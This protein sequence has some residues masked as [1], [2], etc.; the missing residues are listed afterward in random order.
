MRLLVSNVV[1]LSETS[2]DSN[3]KQCCREYCDNIL[4]LQRA[5][6]TKS[7][8]FESEAGVDNHEAAH[9]IPLNLAS[10]ASGASRM[11]SAPL[12]ASTLSPKCFF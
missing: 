3:I 1:S 10:L 7:L 5:Y 12:P 6:F 8:P 11:N 4:V 9:S 2:I